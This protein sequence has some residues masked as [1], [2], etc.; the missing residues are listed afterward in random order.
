M[1]SCYNR[2]QMAQALQKAGLKHGD[3]VFTHSNVGYFGFPEEGQTS[4]IVFHTI[5][6]AFQDV[7]GEEGTLVVPTFSYSFCNN[8]PFDPD[9]TPSTC[10]MFTELLSL[11]PDAHRSQD[12]IFSVAALGNQAEELTADVPVECFGRGSFW[13]RFLAADGVFCNLNLDAGSTFVHFIERCLNVPYRYDKL[14]TGTIIRH[15]KS[16]KGAAIYFCRDLSN[17]DTVAAFEPFDALARKNGLAHSVSVGHGAIVSI[18]ARDSYNII[19][20]E[21]KMNPWLLTSSTKTSK[22]PV[23]RIRE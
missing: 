13:D 7:I 5:L 19:E 8:Q 6:G 2:A 12:P 21:L 18:K 1:K 11:H 14:F 22:T 4:D 17:P 3:V 10:G 15:G 16:E 20:R 23:L 9:N